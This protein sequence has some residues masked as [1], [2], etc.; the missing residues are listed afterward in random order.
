MNL[1]IDEFLDHV[2]EWKFNLQAK[3][4]RLTPAQRKA[5]WAEVHEQARVRGLRVI[6]PTE[7]ASGQV[8]VVQNSD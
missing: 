1:D 3:L 4:N 2:D 7:S 5:F 8:H 6:E